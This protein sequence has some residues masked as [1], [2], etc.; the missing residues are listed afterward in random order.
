MQTKQKRRVYTLQS[1]P[2]HIRGALRP[3]LRA[4]LE[5][6]REAPEQD[7]GWKLFLLAPSM[8]L[9]REKGGPA[10]GAGK[11]GRPVISRSLGTNCTNSF[12]S[13]P[14]TAA[15]LEAQWRAERFCTATSRVVDFLSPHGAVS[16]HS[17]LT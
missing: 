7:A 14:A 11:A 10:A 5:L 9:F 12:W 6:W 3:A 17:G 4:G 8:L 1:A 13:Q 2:P 15:D 16:G